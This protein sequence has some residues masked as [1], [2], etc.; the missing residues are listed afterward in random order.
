VP[1]TTDGRIALVAV[2]AIAAWLFVTLPLLYVPASASGFWGWLS[3]EAS[4]FFTFL[5]LIVAAVQLGLFWYQLRLIRVSLDEAKTAATAAADAAKASGRQ[6]D[7]AEQSLA[8]IERPYLFIFDA[9]KLSIEEWTDELEGEGANL[10]VTYSVANYGK[11]PAII[12]DLQAGLGVFSEPLDPLNV[13]YDHPLEI[14]PILAPGETRH[15][16]RQDIAWFGFGTDEGANIVPRFEKH[17][18]LFLWIIIAYRG[19]FSGGHKTSVCWRYD[20]RT[21]TFVNF[22]GGEEHTYQT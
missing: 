1:K 7:A 8:K 20:D 14:S 19:P 2:V 4:G 9:S 11:I 18:S 22:H 21:R 12:E 3:K 6:A 15:E 16:I 17:E 13:D 10:V 5:M